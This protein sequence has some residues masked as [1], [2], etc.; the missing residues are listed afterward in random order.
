MI[1]PHI[2]SEDYYIILEVHSFAGIVEL[3]LPNLPNAQSGWSVLS[4]GKHPKTQSKLKFCKLASST[5]MS[6]GH[7]TPW[8]QITVSFSHMGGWFYSGFNLDSLKLKFRSTIIKNYYCLCTVVNYSRRMGQ[9]VT[10]GI[11]IGQI[12]SLSVVSDSSGPQN[13]SANVCSGIATLN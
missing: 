5:L 2:L 4:N 3:V 13:V 10:S 8:L 1:F 6:L 12:Q 7:N 11:A 9:W